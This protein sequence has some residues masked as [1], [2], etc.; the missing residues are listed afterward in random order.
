MVLYSLLIKM[1]AKQNNASV[2]HTEDLLQSWIDARAKA[3]ILDGDFSCTTITS[4]G[5][6]VVC[7]HS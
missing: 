3:D 4:E 5:T 2:V 1:N 6:K 7:W